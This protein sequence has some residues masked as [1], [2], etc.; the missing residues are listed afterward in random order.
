MS[1]QTVETSVDNINEIDDLL[2]FLDKDVVI[3]S[4][5][6][7]DAFCDYAYA[8]SKGPTRGDL[9]NHKGTHVTHEDLQAKFEKLNV[10]L[11]HLDDAY[12]GNNNQTTLADL[13]EEIET[14]NYSVTAFKLSG[15]EENKSVI[16]A[17]YKQVNAGVISFETP[18]VKLQGEYLYL[19]ELKVRLYELIN[20]VDEYRL[21]KTASEIDLNQTYMEFSEEDDDF[22]NGKVD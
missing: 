20:E 13:E 7:K 18:K 19:H 4:A 5:K 12:T 22:E 3:K 16:L 6:I 11:A 15:S 17:G 9:I 1:N 14:E 2:A 10:F 8:L 21:G